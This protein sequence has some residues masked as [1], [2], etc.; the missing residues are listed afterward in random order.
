ML[1][2]G[3]QGTRPPAEV[4]PEAANK[5]GAL[6]FEFDLSI[7]AYQDALPARVPEGITCQLLRVAKSRHAVMSP[8]YGR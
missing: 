5:L 2:N 3:G 8:E 4:I 6:T 1:G 7:D